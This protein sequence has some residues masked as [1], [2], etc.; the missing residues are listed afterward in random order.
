MHIDFSPPDIREEDIEAVTRVLRSGWITTGPETKTFEK[1]ISEYCGTEK[2]LCVNSATAG[3]FLILKLIGVKP[4]DEVIVPAYTYTASAST[5]IH[6]GATPVMIDSAEYEFRFDYDKISAAI[7]PKTKAIVCVDLGGIMLDYDRIFKEVES[8]KDIFNP[9]TDIQS[10][11][12]RI[13]VV[14]DAAHSLGARRKGVMSGN[15]AD[16][17]SFSFHAVKNLTTAEGGA[18]T[19]KKNEKLDAE[20][21]YRQL[22]CLSLHGQSKDALAKNKK[23]AWEYDI[24]SSAYKY[25]LTDIASALG[26]SQLKRYE[27]LIARRKE[28]I[29]RYERELS[30]LPLEFPKHWGDDFLSS[31]HLMFVKVKDAKT[32]EYIKEAQRN[33]IIQKVA[34]CDVATNVHYKPLPLFTAYKNLGYKIEDYPNAFNLY[35]CEI[36]LPLYTKLT[37]EM[38]TYVIESFRKALTG[39]E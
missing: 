9:E 7:T 25:N 6:L 21:I 39:E 5:I 35:Q 16:F 30:D 22:N 28:M 36:T 13:A 34:E 29:E 3:L 17:T 4:G 20:E 37:D 11:L 19:W 10:K 1:E 2:T 32:G 26:R 14:C 15:A 33:E 23:G 12:G 31:C 27:S 38:Q 8:K 24:V 18:I